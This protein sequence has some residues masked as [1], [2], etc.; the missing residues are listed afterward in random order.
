M[1]N[2]NYINVNNWPSVTQNLT[3]TQ[4]KQTTKS[5]V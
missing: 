1:Q 5:Q 3:L 4:N 2:T